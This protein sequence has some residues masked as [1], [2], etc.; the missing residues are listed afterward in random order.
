MASWTLASAGGS[1]VR[2]WQCEGGEVAE[3]ALLSPHGR[4]GVACVRWDNS[5]G[6]VL[7]GGEDGHAA[8]STLGSREPPVVLPLPETDA[9]LQ[10][11]S[12][13]GRPTPALHSHGSPEPLPS[14]QSGRN[15]F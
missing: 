14:S 5:G 13:C 4:R 15:P 1:E 9:R 8:V 3:P 6:M 10:P 11:V 12:R 7:S 2:I